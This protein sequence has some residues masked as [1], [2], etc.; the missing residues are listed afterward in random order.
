MVFCSTILRAKLR[1]YAEI[2]KKTPHLFRL[3]AREGIATRFFSCLFL[4]SQ[5][6]LLTIDK[7]IPTLGRCYFPRQK[8]LFSASENI[9]FPVRKR[10]FPSQKILFSK[11]ENVVFPVRKYCFPS[12][13]TLFSKSENTV[14][15]VRKQSLI[16]WPVGTPLLRRGHGEVMKVI[17]LLQGKCDPL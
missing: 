9:V 14:F 15:R 8:T 10:C 6:Q 12:Q 2:T 3:S 11:S 17:S 7:S 1:H 5:Y 4:C 13:K 16:G